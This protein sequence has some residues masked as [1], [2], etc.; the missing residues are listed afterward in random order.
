MIIIFAF[1]LEVT[2]TVNWQNQ[3][4]QQCSSKAMNGNIELNILD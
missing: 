3:R 1:Y 4:T 2:F